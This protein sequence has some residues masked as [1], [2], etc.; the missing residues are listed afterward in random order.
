MRGR[1]LITPSYSIEIYE[2]VF[3]EALGKEKPHDFSG[4][5]DTK[6]R[7]T[8]SLYH[9]REHSEYLPGI[10]TGDSGAVYISLTNRSI[11]K[12]NSPVVSI[13]GRIRPCSP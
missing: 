6:A 11:I 13:N 10:L 3:S 12:M 9:L 2:H 5:H 7:V 1:G 8:H 4:E